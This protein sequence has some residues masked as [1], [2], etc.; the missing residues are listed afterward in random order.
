MR[1]FFIFIGYKLMSLTVKA[2]VHSTRWLQT[3]NIV[4]LA[5]SHDPQ[6][7]LF[8]VTMETGRAQQLS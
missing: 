4:T 7:V 3:P 8:S 2:V 1:D 5:P 6:T